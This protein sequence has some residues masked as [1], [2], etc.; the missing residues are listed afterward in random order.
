MDHWD[1]IRIKYDID[2]AHSEKDPQWAT[3]FIA[4]DAYAIGL[5][6]L[7]NSDDFNNIINKDKS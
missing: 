4:E 1:C 5:T 2:P 7:Q 6:D 3:N